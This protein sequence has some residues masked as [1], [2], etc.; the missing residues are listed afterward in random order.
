MN[1]SSLSEKHLCYPLW[2]DV[3]DHIREMFSFSKS[4]LLP[5]L[6]R[7]LS[8]CS[9]LL[10]PALLKGFTADIS[11]WAFIWLEDENIASIKARTFKWTR[12]SY[13]QQDFMCLLGPY[14]HIEV[15]KKCLIF[16][17]RG[18]TLTAVWS[19]SVL[20]SML[21]AHKAEGEK[22]R[23]VDRFGNGAFWPLGTALYL[24]RTS[25]ATS[26]KAVGLE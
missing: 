7:W 6:P 1:C 22:G 18:G 16:S 19:W 21:P 23:A 4:S 13:L 10:L 11:S 2:K 24:S 25:W 9:P 26:G 12:R 3:R 14:V 5:A 17:P 15:Y 8:R 20:C